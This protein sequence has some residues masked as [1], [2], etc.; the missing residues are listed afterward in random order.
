M[1]QKIEE[2]ED[3]AWNR[4]ISLWLKKSFFFAS[5]EE[6]SVKRLRRRRSIDREEVPLEVAQKTEASPITNEFEIGL[7][8]SVGLSESFPKSLKE[9][10]G[11][12][13]L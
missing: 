9:L 13:S 6:V 4:T 12:L 8:N 10:K 2:I 7:L 3:G 1:F 11:F 5:N